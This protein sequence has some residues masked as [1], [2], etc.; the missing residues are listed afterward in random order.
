VGVPCP[1]KK[2]SKMMVPTAVVGPLHLT[3]RRPIW[4]IMPERV[5]DTVAMADEGIS[6][7]DVPPVV[8]VVVDLQVGIVTTKPILMMKKQIS[9]IMISVIT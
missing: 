4:N 6:I 7:V 1:I 9:M 8:V 2:Y 5:S 3:V